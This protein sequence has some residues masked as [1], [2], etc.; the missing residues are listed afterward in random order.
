MKVSLHNVGRKFNKQ[1][2][3]K[4]INHHF[5]SGSKTAILGGNGSGKSTLIKILTYSLSASQGELNY[6]LENGN[7]VKPSDIALK[8]SLA[9]P[10]LELIEELTAIEFLNF[11]QKFKPFLKGINADSFLEICY[12]ESSR[13]KEIKNFSSGMKQRF[14]LSLALLSNTPLV[15]LDEPTSN[16]DQKGIAW[17]KDLVEKYLSERTIIIGSN[18]SD[19]EISFCGERLVIED[20]K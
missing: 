16:L 9:A 17:Y 20:F 14:R 15:L 2:I 7:E 18:Y 13:N 3:F 10:Y 6:F 19:D 12:L 11:Y 1:Q 8:I 5:E 4:G